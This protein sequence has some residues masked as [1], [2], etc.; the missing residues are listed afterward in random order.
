[1][2]KVKNWNQ[3]TILSNAGL[4]NRPQS[5]NDFSNI[6]NRQDQ[7]QQQQS[8]TFLSFTTQQQSQNQNQ[9]QNQSNFYLDLIVFSNWI[10]NLNPQDNLTM[11]DYL[12][13]N[14]PLDIL[15]TFK[16]KLDLHLQG[17]SAQNQQLQQLQLLPQFVMSPYSQYDQQ[18]YN[19]MDK[20]NM[21]LTTQYSYGDQN[22]LGERNPSLDQT[23]MASNTSSDVDINDYKT[24]DEID[25]IWLQ[26]MNLKNQDTIG[27]PGNTQFGG[28]GSGNWTT[29]FQADQ[30]NMTFPQVS[31]N[32]AGGN[33]ANVSLGQGSELASGSNDMGH[34][35]YTNNAGGPGTNSLFNPLPNF[36]NTLIDMNNLFENVPLDELF[37]DFS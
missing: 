25:S 14:L 24:N 20:L 16:S 27:T 33:V 23:S 12:C 3:F 21:E 22:L 11:I 10:E 5:V 34:V 29:S 1:M 4:S 8:Q 28:G 2:P 19:D 18:L 15:L 6:F 36:P 7:Q 31:N 17:G 30:S 37:K 9:N 13:S 32:P 26:M 35:N